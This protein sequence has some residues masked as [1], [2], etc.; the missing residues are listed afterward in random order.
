MYGKRFTIPI[1][2]GFPESVGARRPNVYTLPNAQR[3]TY[4]QAYIYQKRNYGRIMIDG[5]SIESAKGKGG[6][7]DVVTLETKNSALAFAL[8]LDRQTLMDGTGRLAQEN[9]APAGDV[10]TVDH[11]G[12]SATDTPLTKWFRVG[13]VVDIISAAGAVHADS[14]TIIAVDATTITLQAGEAAACIDDDWIYPEDTYSFAAVAG[15]KYGEMIGI[16][17]IINTANKPE[18]TDFEGI[19]RAAVPQWQ[20]YVNPTTAI[21]SDLTIQNDIDAIEAQTDGEP[22]TL[23]LTT[24]L[25]RNKMISLMNANRQTVNSLDL[26]AGWKAIKYIGGDVELAVM[27]HRKAMFENIYYLNT[28]HLRL[29]TLM[30]LKWDDKLG[31]VLK[32]VAGADAFESWYKLYAQFGSD[33]PNSLGKHELVTIV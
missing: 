21:I 9:G 27:T 16:E 26:K 23:M 12:G 28:E 29:Y 13:Q 30:D 32:G 11:A 31:G 3:S 5:L 33:M 10:I 20:A 15:S 6:W 22:P 25:I 1:T 19:D 18:T 7:L 8:N 4:D 14:A 24:N 2:L 17:G